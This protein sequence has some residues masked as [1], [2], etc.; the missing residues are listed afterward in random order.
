MSQYT[1]TEI[2]RPKRNLF[3]LRLKEIWNYRDLLFTFVQRDYSASYKQTILGPLWHIIQ[4]IFPMIMYTFV[5][6]KIAKISTDGLPQPLFYLSGLLLWN[7]FMDCFSRTSNV[8]VSNAGIFG[9]VYFPRLVTPISFVISSLMRFGSQLILFISIWIYYRIYQPELFIPNIQAF[10]FPFLIILMAGFAL[11]IGMIVSSLSSRYRDLS[12]L[13]S[14]F[15]GL[16]QYATCVI[17]PLSAVPE[18]Y[19]VLVQLNPLTP[20]IESFRYGFMGSG[21]FSYGSLIYSFSCM[22]ILLVFGVLY[23]NRVERT[24]MDTV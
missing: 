3:D 4:P 10:L 5:F 6:G 18:K 17:Y 24:F 7:Y 2:I 1:Y 9:K 11:G 8:F 20:V 22:I 21:T 19:R 23:F 16:L 15:V 14:F 13:V 12:I